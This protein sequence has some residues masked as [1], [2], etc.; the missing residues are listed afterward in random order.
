MALMHQSLQKTV[1]MIAQLNSR[2]SP[3][4]A[5]QLSPLHQFKPQRPPFQKLYST[6]PMTLLFLSQIVTYKSVAFYA[7]VHDWAHTTPTNRQLSVAISSD[8]LASLPSSISSMFLND[9][10]FVSDVIAMISSLT[11]HLNPSSKENLLLAISVLTRLKIRPVKSSI[12]YMSRVRGISKRMQGETI[13]RIIPFFAIAS[14]GHDSYLGVKSQYL[15]GDTTMVNCDLLQLSGLLSSKERIQRALGIMN[16]PPST[17][18]DNRVSNTPSNPPHNRRPA[19]QPPQ[20]PKKSSSV[21]YPPARG[22][23]WKCISVMMQ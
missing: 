11:T 12:D 20:P 5:Q 4:P 1:T 2:P 22:V 18:I 15:A 9:S 6:P 17:T 23:P 7:G 13:D 21:A 14:L 16:V 19:L 10:R 8:M 3:Q